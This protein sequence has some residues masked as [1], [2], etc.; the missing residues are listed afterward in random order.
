MRAGHVVI[1]ILNKLLADTCL[2]SV[3]ILLEVQFP[4]LLSN[5]LLS[6]ESI[7]KGGSGKASEAD[8]LN[9]TPGRI[10]RHPIGKGARCC[11]LSHP[12]GPGGISTVADETV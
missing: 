11:T 2:S 6:C 10:S 1:Q 5:Y 12:K 3:S 9:D 7:T 8:S 4:E